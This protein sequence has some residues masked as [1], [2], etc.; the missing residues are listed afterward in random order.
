MHVINRNKADIQAITVILTSFDSFC[1]F[2]TLAS[3]SVTRILICEKEEEKVFYIRHQLSL[4]TPVYCCGTVQQE[5]S[6]LSADNAYKNSCTGR[7][8]IWL[9]V[10]EEGRQL[11]V[12]YH[13][14]MNSEVMGGIASVCKHLHR[15]LYPA[16]PVVAY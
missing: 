8:V 2:C 5:R 11:T 15:H 13:S 14:K 3:C 7:I 12:L 16:E 4:C 6:R 10:F 9:V 1:W